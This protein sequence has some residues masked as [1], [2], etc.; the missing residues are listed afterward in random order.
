MARSRPTFRDFVLPCALLAVAGLI[1]WRT[2]TPALHKETR[3]DAEL[4]RKAQA[5][6]RLEAEIE[7]LRAA[8][9]GLADPETIER[10]AREQDGAAG[11]PANE[12]IV[13]PGPGEEGRGGGR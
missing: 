7:R 4:E 9:R 1:W 12:V 3:L 2:T 13:A 6:E 8:E 5:Q 10:F 11:L